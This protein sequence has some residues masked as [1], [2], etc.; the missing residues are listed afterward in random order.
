MMM[1]SPWKGWK[2]SLNSLAGIRGTAG[3]QEDV[4]YWEYDLINALMPAIIAA[5]HMRDILSSLL[6]VRYHCSAIMFYRTACESLG[7]N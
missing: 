1:L 2:Y 5:S 4:R 3:V 7:L 6:V